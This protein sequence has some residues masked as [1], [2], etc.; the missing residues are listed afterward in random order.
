MGPDLLRLRDSRRRLGIAAGQRRWRSRVL[1]M[2]AVR[3]DEIGLAVVVHVRH[4]TIDVAQAAG[5]AGHPSIA[6]SAS[7]LASQRAFTSASVIPH[8]FAHRARAPMMPSNP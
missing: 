8:A 7:A 2:A 6:I 4:V 5:T 3:A 1:T